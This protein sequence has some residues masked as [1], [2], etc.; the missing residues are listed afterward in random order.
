MIDFQR[1]L[2]LMKRI[3]QAVWGIQLAN[4]Q[5]MG[6]TAVLS[7]MPKAHSTNSKIEMGLMAKEKAEQAYMDAINE[8]HELR[9]L[10]RPCIS[11]LDNPTYRAALYLRY[12]MGQHPVAMAEIM[13]LCTRQVYRVLQAAQDEVNKSCH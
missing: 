13:H 6:I 2:Y 1:M 11:N 3:P 9:N 12:I 4:T 10:L 5:A 7:D 8:L